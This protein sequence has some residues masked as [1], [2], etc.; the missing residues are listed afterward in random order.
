MRRTTM[1]QIILAAALVILLGAGIALAERVNIKL[2]NRDGELVRL[3]INGVVEELRLD[4][5]ADG[6]SRHFAAGDH[7]ITV[8]RQG[9]RLELTHDGED[10]ASM[11]H[12]VHGHHMVWVGDH[13]DCESDAHG[14]ATAQKVI[15]V[16]R[17]DEPGTQVEARVFC[18]GG[19]H[20]GEATID[21]EEIETRLE[22]AGLEGLE[23]DVK[24]E[25][26]FIMK[27][28]GESPHPIVIEGHGWD[29]ADMVRYRCQESGSMLLVPAEDAIEDVYVDPATGCLLERV[30]EPERR[31][32]KIITKHH[33]EEEI[34]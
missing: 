28:D 13:E 24:D 11:H 7:T 23:L 32:L 2:E 29:G 19:D 14:D 30:Q 31:V 9:D 33:D 15:V 5:L 17:G 26:V 4:D 20:E 3:D 16:K 8:T 21:I 6:E 10:F 12:A 34:E 22:A 25:K 27:M 1:G 18:L